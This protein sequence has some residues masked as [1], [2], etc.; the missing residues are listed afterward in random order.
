[1]S[2][3]TRAFASSSTGGNPIGGTGT[4]ASESTGGRSTGGG[5]T[6]GGMS[7]GGQGVGGTGATGGIATGGVSTAVIATGGKT[8]G[9]NATGGMSTGGNATGGVATGGNA[10]GGVAA[11]GSTGLSQCVTGGSGP[12]TLAWQD[13]FNSLNTALWQLQSFTFATNLAQFTPQNAKVANGVLTISLTPNSASTTEPYYGVEMRSAQT[14]TYGKVSAR[15]R[16]AKGSGVV[17]GLVL[18][19]T[20][21][22]NC[23]WNEIDIEHLGNSS[24]SSQLNC[25]VFTG[26]PVSNCTASVTATQDPQ[27]TN[28]GFNAET[29]FHLYDIEWTPNNVKFYADCTLLRTWS[30]NPSKMNLPQTILLTIWA[31]ST[32]SWAGAV[33]A[34]TAPTSADIDWIKVYTYN[35]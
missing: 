16:F 27:I 15:M 32:A 26:T 13:D 35:G 3:G 7:V 2:G 9:G 21:Y 17:S 22:P 25:Q 12:F 29:D 6:G 18:F 1:M 33:N 5:A 23:N 28:L 14:I 19:Y 30:T 8:T 24:N 34:N 31:S 4:R 20:P 11:G 10:A